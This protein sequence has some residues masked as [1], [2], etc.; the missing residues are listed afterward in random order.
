MGDK[1][2]VFFNFTKFCES[3]YY[4]HS[5]K[6]CRKYKDSE[7]YVEN[8]K[9]YWNLKKKKDHWEKLSHSSRHKTA[10]NCV[11]GGEIGEHVKKRKRKEKDGETGM[12]PWWKLFWI[13]VLRG[14]PKLNFFKCTLTL[15]TNRRKML[16]LLKIK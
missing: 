14:L 15:R 11:N 6:S 4:C 9:E 7:K 3:F 8:G 2:Q 5:G 1:T 12:V 16:L 10:P 13:Q